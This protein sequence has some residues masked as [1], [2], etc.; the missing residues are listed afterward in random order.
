MPS[1]H[2]HFHKKSRKT[3]STTEHRPQLTGVPKAYLPYQTVD[4]LPDHL[5]KHKASLQPD[6]PRT[7]LRLPITRQRQPLTSP[8]GLHWKQQQKRANSFQQI[9]TPMKTINDQGTVFQFVT[10]LMT[11][12][13]VPMQP[14]LVQLIQDNSL[15]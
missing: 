13:Q 12:T 4:P 7:L 2:M 14:R 9:A 6:G 8:N 1:V 10:M 15:L 3:K 5:Q 11:K